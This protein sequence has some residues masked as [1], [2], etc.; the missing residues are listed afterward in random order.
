MTQ[1]YT[2]STAALVIGVSALTEILSRE[3]DLFNWPSAEL[4][5]PRMIVVTVPSSFRICFA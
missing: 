4:G 5:R 3:V 2:R 1:R